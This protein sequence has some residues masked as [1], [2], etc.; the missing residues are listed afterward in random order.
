VRTPEGL[1]SC[2]STRNDPEVALFV[3]LLTFTTDPAASETGAADALN[4][5]LGVAGGTGVGVGT[6]L[7]AVTSKGAF[8]VA[9]IGVP[10]SIVR[11]PLAD[12]RCRPTLAVAGTTKEA[13]NEPL[14]LAW[15]VGIPTAEPSHPNV[16]AAS[17]GKFVPFATTVVPIVPDERDRES[18]A[19]CLASAADCESSL[20]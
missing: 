13:W 10:F 9:V 3:V 6:V 15:T 7:T 4:V 5:K 1:K 11:V 20:I 2:T 16:T 19:G 8:T 14:R 18:V 12:T 17:R